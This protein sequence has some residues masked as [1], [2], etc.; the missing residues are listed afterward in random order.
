MKFLIYLLEVNLVFVVLYVTYLLFIKPLPFYQYKRWLLIASIVLSFVIPI[1]HFPLGFN[2]GI[3][4]V[5]VDFWKHSVSNAPETNALTGTENPV[6]TIISEPA[7]SST[8]FHWHIMLLLIYFSGILVILIRFIAS[9]RKYLIIHKE[10]Q[11]WQNKIYITNAATPA[12][13]FAGRI[14]IHPAVVNTPDAEMIIQHEKVHVQQYHYIDN[15]LFEIGCIILWYN[16]FVWLCR[17]E[18]NYNGEMIA[19]ELVV[20]GSSKIDYAHLL[21]KYSS[22][23]MMSIINSFAHVKVKSRIISLLNP[24]YDGNKKKRFLIFIPLSLILIIIFSCE[25]EIEYPERLTLFAG[26]SIKSVEAIFINEYGDLP[27]KHERII[28]TI[29]FNKSG[30]I[31]N[32]KSFITNDYYIPEIKDVDSGLRFI[33]TDPFD[34]ELAYG[35]LK[36]GFDWCEQYGKLIENLEYDTKLKKY[37]SAGY[38]DKAVINVDVEWQ[39]GIPISIIENYDNRYADRKGV[40]NIVPGKV[41]FEKYQSFDFDKT[42]KRL[43]HKYQSKQVP[44]GITINYYENELGIKFKTIN[45][46]KKTV[47]EFNDSERLIAVYRSDGSLLKTFE[48]LDGKLLDNYKV[49]NLQ[50][51]LEYSVKIKYTYY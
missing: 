39:D 44:D 34:P 11:H 20:A 43:V 47:Y 19:D 22:S 7:L 35:F 14:Y 29:A 37:E 45:E 27:D 51:E 2:N 3:E 41:Q 13:S 49:Y 4:M 21:L 23:N 30:E 32:Q 42:K 26:K 36:Y 9:L 12:F 1:L 17:E 15:L 28:K 16:P 10:S 33:Y 31:N 8:T 25:N 6:N 50:S 38:L 24:Y 5:T 46:D 18:V 40:I 48:Y